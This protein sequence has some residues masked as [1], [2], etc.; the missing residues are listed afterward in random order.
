MGESLFI[1]LLPGFLGEPAS[2]LV[3]NLLQAV[4]CC[5]DGF[6]ISKHGREDFVPYLD[7]LLGL[8]QVKS[9]TEGPRS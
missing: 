4:A 5:E 6:L 2:I 7:A 9:L 3:E 1:G 8:R